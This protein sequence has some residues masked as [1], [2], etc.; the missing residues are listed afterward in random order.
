MTIK[1]QIAY[2]KSHPFY[3]LALKDELAMDKLLFEVMFHTYTTVATNC[4]RA[5][6]Q[7]RRMNGPQI[8]E[9][10]R[11]CEPPQNLDVRLPIPILQPEDPICV[12]VTLPRS[13]KIVVRS[14]V[15]CMQLVLWA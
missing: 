6:R 13:R 2:I 3:A 10:I 4:S 11:D 5:Y 7:A 12:T 9:A 8:V 1:A 15:D 14:R